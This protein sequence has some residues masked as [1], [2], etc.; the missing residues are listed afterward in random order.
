MSKSKSLDLRLIQ[1][2]LSPIGHR[3]LAKITRY[4]YR[5]SPKDILNLYKNVVQYNPN[6]LAKF[7]FQNDKIIC[8]IVI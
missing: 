1:M 3:K 7:N 8:A 2:S 6:N 4:H 5:I